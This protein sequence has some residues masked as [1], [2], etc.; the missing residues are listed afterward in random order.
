MTEPKTLREISDTLLMPDL[1]RAAA[2]LLRE[3]PVIGLIK[4]LKGRVWV[5]PLGT[6]YDSLAPWTEVKTAEP[7]A[8]AHLP[9][10]A[11]DAPPM[12]GD[13][14]ADMEHG[15][16]MMDLQHAAQ[17]A[18]DLV[19]SLEAL[20]SAWEDQAERLRREFA[21]QVHPALARG[22]KEANLLADCARMLREAI[23]HGGQG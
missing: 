13:V 11:S 7:P 20:A 10:P 2:R 18:R 16:G 6:P 15:I 5:A 21:E 23:T 22:H 19:P 12:L 1:P 14:L 9:R 4:F 8:V 17:L 3:Q